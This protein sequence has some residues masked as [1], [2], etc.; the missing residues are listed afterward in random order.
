MWCSAVPKWIPSC[1]LWRPFRSLYW[2]QDVMSSVVFSWPQWPAKHSISAIGTEVWNC[3]VCK[4]L[5]TLDATREAKHANNPL[6]Q[7]NCRHCMQQAA[8]IKMK[9]GSI[10]RTAKATDDF[11]LLFWNA[12]WGF[13]ILQWPWNVLKSHVNFWECVIKPY[14]SLS[15]TTSHS[16]QPLL[17]LIPKGGCLPTRRTTAMSHLQVSGHWDTSELVAHSQCFFSGNESRSIH[18]YKHRQ[19]LLLGVFENRHWVYLVKCWP[20]ER[21]LVQL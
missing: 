13:Q 7:Q 2:V 15:H 8:C 4:A 20:I 16:L 9:P 17:C 1:S 14:G 11:L 21:N 10:S 19:T 18:E 5:S 6:W 3:E 12:F